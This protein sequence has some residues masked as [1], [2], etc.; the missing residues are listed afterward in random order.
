MPH[1][2]ANALE[3][4]HPLRYRRFA[5]YAP[6][7][8]YH[9]YNSHIAVAI[10]HVLPNLSGL[11]YDILIDVILAALVALNAAIGIAALTPG[12]L[13]YGL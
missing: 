3:P 4:G 10:I 8:K 5:T 7:I 13:P 12:L 1:Y 11:T 2:H 6:T 9:L